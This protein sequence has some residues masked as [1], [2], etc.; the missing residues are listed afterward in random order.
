MNQLIGFLLTFLTLVLALLLLTPLDLFF[1]P[2][3]LLLV[4][5][6]VFGVMFLSYGANAFSI[7]KYASQPLKNQKE[8]FWVIAFFDNMSNTAILTGMVGTIISHIS[9]FYVISSTEQLL[10]VTGQNVLPLVY[11]YILAKLIFE[12]L[13]Q[14]VLRKAVITN[15]NENIHKQVEQ[16]NKIAQRL[17]AISLFIFVVSLLLLLI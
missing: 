16:N 4:I 8:Y 5:G 11:G 9:S 10:A 14:N 17:N 1:Q 3:A 13:K 2:Y 6:C 15:I 12:P 7:F